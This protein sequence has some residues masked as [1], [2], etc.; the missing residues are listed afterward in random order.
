MHAAEF[1]QSLLSYLKET[2]EEFTEFLKEMSFGEL[3]DFVF[4]LTCNKGYYKK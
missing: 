3:E 4:D 2:K 1:P